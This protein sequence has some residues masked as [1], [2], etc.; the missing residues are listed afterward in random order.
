MIIIVIRA[1]GPRTPPECTTATAT[2][3]YSATAHSPAKSTSRYC[4]WMSL[5]GVCGPS[6]GSIATAAIHCR[7]CTAVV[8]EHTGATKCAAATTSAAVRVSRRALARA[9]GIAVS[10]SV[11]VANVP[12]AA[13]SGRHRCGCLRAPD[14]SASSSS[15]SGT[16][17]GTGSSG[18]TARAAHATTVDTRRCTGA[19]LEMAVHVQ[20][21]VIIVVEE[22][23]GQHVRRTHPQRAIRLAAAQRR[24][25]TSTDRRITRSRW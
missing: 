2:A 13:K 9:M 11:A 8:A 25:A 12:K 1:D 17:T 10:T 7:H 3:T 15:S 18:S 20:I 23:C 24:R 4:T 19:A 16:G 14:V 21:I 5:G 6:T 22:G